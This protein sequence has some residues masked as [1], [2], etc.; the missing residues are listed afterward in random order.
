MLLS[1][2]S[3]FR[4]KIE[5]ERKGKIMT[6][7]SLFRSIVLLTAFVL[8]LSSAYA[9]IGRNI[10]GKCN[11]INK[12]ETILC[13]SCQNPLN[14]CLKCGHDNMAKADYCANCSMPLAEMRVL[15]TIAPEVR[16]QLKLGESPRAVADLE[17]KRLEYLL[18]TD[19][20]NAEKHLFNLAMTH[21]RIDFYSRESALWLD[22]LQKYP[23]S[24]K[25]GEARVNG[26]DSLRKWSY[27]LYSQGSYARAVELLNESLRLNPANKEAQKWLKIA[28]GGMKKSGQTAVAKPQAVEATEAAPQMEEAKPAPKTEVA[29]APAEPAPAVEASPKTEAAPAAEPAPATEAAPQ[30]DNP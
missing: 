25:A 26:S 3:V 6:S 16:T 9:M 29:P 13:E 4:V 12:A 1:Q 14:H 5:P 30:T 27:L 17:I 8:V 24:E 11:W 15:A 19:A 10:C 21:K 2:E 7:K 22:F 23:N 18:Q 28:R 20:E